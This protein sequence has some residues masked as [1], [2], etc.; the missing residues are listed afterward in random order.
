MLVLIVSA[1][2][3]ALLSAAGGDSFTS[4]RDNSQVSSET[5]ENLRRIYGLD[6]P[7]AV[8][9][10]SWL[11]DAVR[12]HLG[13]SYYFRTSVTGLVVDRFAYTLT[14]SLVALAV[15]LTI[16]VGLSVLSVRFRRRWLTR[17][18]EAIVL[19]TSST[20]RLVLALFGL[21]LMVRFNALSA[22]WMAVTVLAVPLISVLLAQFHYDLER[23]MA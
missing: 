1:V 9:Y 10:A 19:L 8:R 3:F 20:P 16:A 6:R 18:I 21:A 15:S 2:T 22:F 13:E 11:G 7:L 4:L 5:I 17:V 23:F 14:L 12:G